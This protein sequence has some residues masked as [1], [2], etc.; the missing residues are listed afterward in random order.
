MCTILFSYKTHPSY[1]LIL[2]ANRDE[3]YARPAIPMG[4]WDDKEGVLAG[5]DA[6]MR[7]TWMGI[8]KSGR[9]AAL[10]NYRQMPITE[11]FISSRGAL[12]TEFISK[13]MT[14]D[15]YETILRNDASKYDGYNLI[16]GNVENLRYFS[17]RGADNSELKPGIYGLSNHL[18]DTP[19]PKVVN[20]KIRMEQNVRDE[21][22][23]IDALFA[24]MMN[25]DLGEDSKLPDTGVGIE[26]ERMLSATFIAPIAPDSYR[27]G[28]PE[29][30][31]RCS[32]VLLVDNDNNVTFE[33]RSFVPESHNAY[34]F[35]IK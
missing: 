13:E 29:Y 21:E 6:E 11:T 32:T 24:M 26:L 4:W 2:A 35:T 16:Y 34:K 18:L 30:G 3:F 25:R 1:K 22:I 31:T 23:N 7:G 33:E 15:S 19:W 17:N 10:T 20:G 9:F 5:R 27:D 14:A 28:A 12:V 8:S